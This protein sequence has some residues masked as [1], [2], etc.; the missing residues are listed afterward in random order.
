MAARTK[1]TECRAWSGQGAQAPAAFPHGP[2]NRPSMKAP[3]LRRLSVSDHHG[4]GVGVAL[5]SSC[6]EHSYGLR[7]SKG[8]WSRDCL[9]TA[10]ASVRAEGRQGSHRGAEQNSGASVDNLDFRSSW[11]SPRQHP[12]TDVTGGSECELRTW[13]LSMG[14]VPVCLSQSLA[15]TACALTEWSGPVEG[16]SAWSSFQ[17]YAL[18]TAVYSP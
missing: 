1:D 14:G 12:A 10:P 6:I 2:R 5:P 4:H 8:C 15:N 17:G 13:K 3:L 18:L 7:G 11:K 16:N 9:Q